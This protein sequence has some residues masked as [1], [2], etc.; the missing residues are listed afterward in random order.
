MGDEFKKVMKFLGLGYML[1]FCF[2]LVPYLCA[3]IGTESDLLVVGVMLPLMAWWIFLLI[4]ILSRDLSWEAKY[5]DKKSARESAYDVARVFC[6]L[7]IAFQVLSLVF[8]EYATPIPVLTALSD[9][10]SLAVIFA[11]LALLS[12]S[13]ILAPHF[14]RQLFNADLNYYVKHTTTTYLD[15]GYSETVT[16][17]KFIKKG[18]FIRMALWTSFLSILLAVTPATII[19]FLVLCIKKK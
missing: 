8:A 4:F 3:L 11:A 14:M 16:S 6:A 13:M 5:I 15:F 18:Q 10:T 19:V 1:F 12:G 2:A 17:D 9:E 7:N